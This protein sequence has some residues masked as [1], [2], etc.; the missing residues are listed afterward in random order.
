MSRDEVQR[1]LFGHVGRRRR[2][3][4]PEAPV[5]KAALEYFNLLPGCRA[6]RQN[7]GGAVF[8]GVH[9]E[10]YY[11]RFGE[12]GMSDISG[13]VR[14]YRL[15]AEAKAPGEEPTELQHA[16]LHLIAMNGGVALW[17]DSLEM[18]MLKMH[19]EYRRRGWHVDPV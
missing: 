13:I 12:T 7:T 14:G 8:T 2:R 11:V 19:E 16:W 4:G 10:R 18:C 17:F 1:A 9:G 15:E 6:W 5:L 3:E